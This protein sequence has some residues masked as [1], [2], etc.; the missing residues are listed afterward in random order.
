MWL[1]L[2]RQLASVRHAEGTSGDV[3][4]R[5]DAESSRSPIAGEMF[6]KKK[7]SCFLLLDPST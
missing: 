6:L 3:T 5:T 2:I 7:S 4:D 1:L